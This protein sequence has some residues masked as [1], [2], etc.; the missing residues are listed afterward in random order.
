M[1]HNLVIRGLP[2]HVE[3]YYTCT[4]ESCQ[5]GED[6]YSITLPHLYFGITCAGGTTVTITK[7][8]LHSHYFCHH[9][10][11][12]THS[13]WVGYSFHPLQQFVEGGP[14]VYNKC[15]SSLSASLETRAAGD[16]HDNSTEAM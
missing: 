15:L 7:L 2:V 6:I 16:I 13:C 4:V 8:I 14:P 10:D 1:A 3:N 11:V 9:L 12:Q 5:G